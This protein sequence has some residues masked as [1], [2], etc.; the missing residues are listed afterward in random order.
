MDVDRRLVLKGMALSGI[1]G[2]AMGSSTR[3]LGDTSFAAGGNARPLFA[4]V[5]DGPAGSVFL[6]GAMAV[7]GSRMRAESISLDLNRILHL[8]RELRGAGAMRII[9]LLD[10]AAGTLV[11]DLARS[12]GARV[13]WLGQHTAHAGMSRHHLVTADGARDCAQRLGRE[14]HACGAGF[15]IVSY[16]H[17]D[18]STPRESSEP[19][20]TSAHASDWARALGFVLASLDTSSRRTAPVTSGG[21]AAEGRFVSF[22]IA[23]EESNRG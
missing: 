3:S 23:V 7:A 2:L 6:H 18:P 19:L 4:L 17:D 14:L 10:D 8:E 9:G 16:G 1:A 22:S 20:R 13:Q 11:L 12:T 21:V 5:N 15:H